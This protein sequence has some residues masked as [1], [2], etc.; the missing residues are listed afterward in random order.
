MDKEI[1]FNID[2]NLCTNF[3]YRLNSNCEV[4]M[5][6]IMSRYAGFISHLTFIN[7]LGQ[8]FRII[9]PLDELH[10]LQKF[11]SQ[12]EN[13]IESQF[14]YDL[15]P[16]KD[17][18]GGLLEIDKNGYIAISTLNVFK[19]SYDTVY[20]IQLEDIVNELHY[21]IDQIYWLLVEYYIDEEDE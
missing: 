11:L 1:G 18:M 6:I 14:L 16:S 3:T 20:V 10:Y 7:T 9:L 17:Y 2:E 4:N 8:E 5:K 13:D 12:F 21:F 19:N 15:P